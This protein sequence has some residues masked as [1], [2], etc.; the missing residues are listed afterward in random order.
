MKTNQLQ[1]LAQN[2]DITLVGGSIKGAMNAVGASSRDFWMVGRTAIKLIDGFNVRIDNQALRDHI[3]GLA[4]SMKQN[5][6]RPEHPLSGYVSNEGGELTIYLTDGHC[7]LAAFDLAV[8]EGADMTVLPMVVSSKSKSLEDITAAMVISATGKPLEALEKAFICKRYTLF[9]WDS[10]RIAQRLGFSTPSYVDD[11]LLL[12]GA[13]T[14]VVAMV[15]DS[16]VAAATA[17]DMLKKH[18]NKA[19]QLLQEGLERAKTQG[20]AKLTKR[21]TTDPGLKFV[22]RSAPTLFATVKEISADPA[23]AQ[24]DAGLRDKVQK[25]MDEIAEM[26]AKASQPKEPKAPKA[27]KEPKAT[28]TASETAAKGFV[29]RPKKAHAKVDAA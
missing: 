2:P 20:K 12:A 28:K 13:P 5:G 19:P 1:S 29:S 23:F 15:A 17:I 8:A 7:R 4:D 18:G 22:T 27:A 24:L 26:R 21:F 10:K 16:K 3:R 9:N 6:F 25:L 11:L 14:S